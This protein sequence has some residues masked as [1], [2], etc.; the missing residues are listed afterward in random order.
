MCASE[1]EEQARK[2]VALSRRLRLRAAVFALA[3]LVLGPVWIVSQ[4][5]ESGGWPRRLSP[6]GNPG[7]WSPWL[8]WVALAWGFYVALTAVAIHYRRPPSEREIARALRRHA[9]RP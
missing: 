2:R 6:N 3:M 5:L 9:P 7:D 1:T 4:Y 8:I